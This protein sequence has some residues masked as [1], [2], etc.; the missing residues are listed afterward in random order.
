MIKCVVLLH[1]VHSIWLSVETK[2]IEIKNISRKESIFHVS[3]IQ[4]V[5]NLLNFIPFRYVF[6]FRVPFNPILKR[7]IFFLLSQRQ[8]CEFDDNVICNGFVLESD[9]LRNHIAE[10]FSTLRKN[11][12]LFSEHEKSLKSISS[13]VQ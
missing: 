3:R 12:V 4:N 8:L 13:G 2:L 9:L 7:G 5:D 10:S 11:H 1:R 6:L